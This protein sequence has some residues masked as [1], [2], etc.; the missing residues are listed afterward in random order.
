MKISSMV[1]LSTRSV[2]LR[3]LRNLDKLG[4]FKE[5]HSGVKTNVKVGI[6]MDIIT[7][8]SCQNM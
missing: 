8:Q 7:K 1:T 6:R 2:I 3:I 4:K 5:I